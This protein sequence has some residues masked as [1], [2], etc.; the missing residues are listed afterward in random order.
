MTQDAPLDAEAVDLVAEIDREAEAEKTR[1]LEEA[2]AK[3]AEILA[4][5]EA[6]IQAAAEDADLLT[7]KRAR[8]D[9]DRLHGDARMDALAERLRGLR[10]VYQLVFETARQR[11]DSLVRSPE[12][13]RAM[14]ALIQEALAMV[15]EAASIS[16]APEDEEMCRRILGE[17]GATCQIKTGDLDHGSILVASADGKV[18][19]DNSLTVRLATAETLL[20][21]RIAR[22][23]DG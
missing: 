10:Q 18:T 15:P 9:E 14:R 21:T 3:A 22:C 8:A 7:E 6:R 2:R 12:Y 11:I 19:V 5:A 23:L 16:V 4:A 20:E 13:A 17:L 1:I